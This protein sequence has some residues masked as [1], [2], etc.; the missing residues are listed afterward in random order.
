MKKS[1]EKFNESPNVG[2]E[3]ELL[4]VTFIFWGLSKKMV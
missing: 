1:E 2:P 4:R 3:Q